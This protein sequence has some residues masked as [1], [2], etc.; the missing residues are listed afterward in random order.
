[1]RVFE[2]QKA[3]GPTHPGDQRGM[4]VCGSFH[5]GSIL[6]YHCILREAPDFQCAIFADN[7]SLFGP[8]AQQQGLEAISD[9]CKAFRMSILPK[10]GAE[11]GHDQDRQYGNRSIV[12]GMTIDYGMAIPY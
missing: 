10:A 2:I 3:C 1:M 5:A 6:A 4:Q 7:W 9:L 12:T 8:S 11:M